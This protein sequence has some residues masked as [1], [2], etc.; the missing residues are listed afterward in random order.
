[1]TQETA[2]ISPAELHPS[3]QTNLMQWEEKVIGLESLVAT[4]AVIDEIPDWY[5]ER[6]TEESRVD[7][8]YNKVYETSMSQQIV[9]IT[10]AEAQVE[11]AEV[12]IDLKI[13]E[14]QLMNQIYKRELSIDTG[15]LTSRLG[16]D[17]LARVCNGDDK[18]GIK[19]M[20]L[21][22]LETEDVVTSELKLLAKV[23]GVDRPTDLFGVVLQDEQENSR[24][25]NILR[26]PN[27]LKWM[28][29]LEVNKSEGFD[30]KSYKEQKQLDYEWMSEVTSLAGGVEPRLAQ[31]YCFSASKRGS[32]ETL[33]KILEAFDVFG[34]ERIKVYQTFSEYT[35]WKRTVSISWRLWRRF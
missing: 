7:G 21:T 33:P 6:S 1:M 10:D 3:A 12:F 34:A 13:R 23:Y 25:K 30:E 14:R 22:E 16:E 24:L 18:S 9:E 17:L 2:T 15:Y 28:H 27:T 29:H 11:A 31:D 32:D 4:Q 20:L 35:V 5:Y 8:G 19:D 26:K